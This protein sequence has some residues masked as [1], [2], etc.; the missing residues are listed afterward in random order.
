MTPEER[1]PWKKAETRWV[2]LTG[3]NGQTIGGTIHLNVVLA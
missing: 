2:E 3:G 1:E